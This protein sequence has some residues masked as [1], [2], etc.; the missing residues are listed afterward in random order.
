MLF[1]ATDYLFLLLYTSTTKYAYE[2]SHAVSRHAAIFSNAFRGAPETRYCEGGGFGELVRDSFE[3]PTPPLCP[4][5]PP[6]NNPV[7]YLRG[8]VRWTVPNVWEF[9]V[10]HAGDFSF[11]P[12]DG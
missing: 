7:G 6:F 9:V 2:K 3:H 4:L 12:R 10:R 8:F 11:Q 1:N 5:K